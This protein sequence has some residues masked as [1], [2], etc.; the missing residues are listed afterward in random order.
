MGQVTE[1][2]YKPEVFGN[3]QRYIIFCIVGFFLG[4]VI[5]CA[6][7]IGAAAVEKSS[8]ETANFFGF[9]GLIVGYLVMLG[10][11]ITG[12]VIFLI[13]LY[14][15]WNQ[16]QDGEVEV[17]PGKAVGFLFI[18]FFNLYWAFIAIRGLALEMNDYA[19]RHRIRMEPVNEQIPTFFII[20]WICMGIPGVAIATIILF[21]LTLNT[22][23][24][25]AMTIAR[26]KLRG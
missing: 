17:S 14:R 16:I 10:S 26:A 13:M 7:V 9:G 2:N 3:V 18:P 1:T 5:I 11:Y 4:I 21:F 19:E 8:R 23:K 6:G 25:A 22:F 15:M 12:L 24:N 20:S